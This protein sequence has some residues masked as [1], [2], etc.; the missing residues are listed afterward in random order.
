MDVLKSDKVD[1]T[2]F[3]GFSGY[4][5]LVHGHGRGVP[6]EK[7]KSPDNSPQSLMTIG[8]NDLSKGGFPESKHWK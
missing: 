4:W 7:Q 3:T 6:P 2:G 1:S 5:S 8:T